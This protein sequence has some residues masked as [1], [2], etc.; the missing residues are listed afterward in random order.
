MKEDELII[1]I[2]NFAGQK[3]IK[4]G[5]SFSCTF[6]GYTKKIPGQDYIKIKGPNSAEIKI[7]IRIDKI[8]LADHSS[9]VSGR[10]LERAIL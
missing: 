2:G 4:R 7:A 1:P 3:I 5:A 6:E 10:F 9:Y 8:I